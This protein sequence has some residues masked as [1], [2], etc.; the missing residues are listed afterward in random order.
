MQMQEQLDQQR[1]EKVDGDDGDGGDVNDAEKE[2]GIKR[3][4]YVVFCSFSSS[5]F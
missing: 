1:K 4:V 5:P 2:R 3:S